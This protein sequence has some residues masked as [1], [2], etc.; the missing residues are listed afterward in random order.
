[1]PI[2]AAKYHQRTHLWTWCHLTI[3][4]RPF[5]SPD[6][7]CELGFYEEEARPGQALGEM[8]AGMAAKAS[9]LKGLVGNKDDATLTLK[10]KQYGT[11]CF[12]TGGRELERR[13]WER[14]THL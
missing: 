2:A 12:A 6:S 1:M 14:H 8:E 4:G 3:Q 13:E 7:M 9:G 11:A 10:Q 5:Q